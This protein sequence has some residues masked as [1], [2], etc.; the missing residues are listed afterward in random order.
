MQAQIKVDNS[1]FTVLLFS[2][3]SEMDMFTV[4]S[5]CCKSN[6]SIIEEQG[7]VSYVNDHVPFLMPFIHIPMCF[8]NFF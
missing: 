3:K 5:S 7:S 4:I 6:D 8:Y 2:E 1:L